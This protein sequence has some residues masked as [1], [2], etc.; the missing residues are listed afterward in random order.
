MSPLL[1]LPLATG[2]V[3][4]VVLSRLDDIDLKKV[5]LPLGTTDP[6]RPH[7]PICVS[8]DLETKSRVVIVFGESSQAFGLR[9]YRVC[10]RHGGINKGS[11]VG[12]VKALQEQK[13]SSSDD[14]PPGV[15][16]ANMGEL[17]WWPDGPRGLTFQGRQGIPM[18][19]SVHTERVYAKGENTV[20][21]NKNAEEHVRYIFEEVL[22]NMVSTSAKLDIIAIGASA[23][24]V[25]SYLNNDNVW[26]KVGGQL[27]SMAVIGGFYDFSRFVCEGFTTF[28]KEVGSPT[29]QSSRPL[30]TFTARS[31]LHSGRLPG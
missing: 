21:G 31:S 26:A 23:E 17:W 24:E 13:S 12:F 20:P 28:M 8:S 4:E 11:M 9:S 27:N 18:S 6:S 29:M 1:T 30:L 3:E 14:S 10:V 5:R 25:E 22:P 2:A 15:V 19:S 16:L 7:V